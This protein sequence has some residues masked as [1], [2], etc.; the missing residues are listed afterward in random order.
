MNRKCINI[1]TYLL[2]LA[3]VAGGSACSLMKIKAQSPEQK[4]A[5]VNTNSNT[6]S[7]EPSYKPEKRV[8]KDIIKKDVVKTD[9]AKTDVKTSKKQS[10]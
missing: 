2:L 4:S 5:S 9:V 1:L 6:D 10:K 8:S 7:S 3:A